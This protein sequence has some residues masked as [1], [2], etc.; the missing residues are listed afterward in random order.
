M[1]C[2]VT[3]PGLLSS[4]RKTVLTAKKSE[5]KQKLVQEQKDQKQTEKDAKNEMLYY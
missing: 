4:T 3:D 1:F 5:E 2:K